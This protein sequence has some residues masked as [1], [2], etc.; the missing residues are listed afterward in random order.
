M[1]TEGIVVPT[2][3]TAAL[4]IGFGGILTPI[5]DFMKQLAAQH[6]ERRIVAVIPEL[7]DGRWFHWLLHTQ[8]A[9]LLKG[10]LLME[11]HDRISVLNI[12]CY[13]ESS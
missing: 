9:E 8:H 13:Q 5:I 3:L 11:G 6:H 2:I 12:A 1:Y 4:L 7:V 10:R